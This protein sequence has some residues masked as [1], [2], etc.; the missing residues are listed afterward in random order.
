MKANDCGFRSCT[1]DE[2]RKQVEQYIARQQN[3][4]SDSQYHSLLKESRR[5]F[6]RHRF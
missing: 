5:I 4:A 1:T 6:E 3:E 2:E